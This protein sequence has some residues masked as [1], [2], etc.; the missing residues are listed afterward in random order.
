VRLEFAFGICLLFVVAAACGGGESELGELSGGSGAAGVGTSL[1]GSGQG[2][3][4]ST[5]GASSGS[6]GAEMSGTGGGLGASS[7]LG[8]SFDAGGDNGFGAATGM[9]GFPGPGGSRGQG[10][11]GM[12]PP[13][14]APPSPDCVGRGPCGCAPFECPQDRGTCTDGGTCDGICVG[15]YCGDEW[16]CLSVQFCTEDISPWCGC[17]GETFYASSSCPSKAFAHP[18]MCD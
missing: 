16:A 2:G 7:G 12:C 3:S 15:T 8:G 13:C 4:P 11:E 1:G 9:G 17:D 14:Q 18:G 5:A 10:G 6:G